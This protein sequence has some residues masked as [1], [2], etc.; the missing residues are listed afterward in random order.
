[1]DKIDPAEPMDKI[2]PLDPMLRI[3]PDEPSPHG[4]GPAKLLRPMRLFSHHGARGSRSGRGALS[5]ATA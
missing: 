1:M 3:E 2:D 5:G 4:P